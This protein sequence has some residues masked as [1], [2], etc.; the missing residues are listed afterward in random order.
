MPLT[1]R[2]ATL[3]GPEALT[4]DTCPVADPGPGE[5]RLRVTAALVGG[6]AAEIWRRGRHPRGGR[7]PSPFGHEGAGVIDAIG[8]G[9]T[10]WKP[11][12][13]VLAAGGVPCGTCEF[14][15]RGSAGQCDA[16][17]W[18]LGYA[19]ER[20]VVPAPIVQRS[21]HRLPDGLAPERAALAWELACVL[22]GFDRSPVGAGRTAVVIGAGAAGLLWVRTLS[23]AGARVVAVDRRRG[24]LEKAKS[25]GA[26]ETVDV[27]TSD[28]VGHLVRTKTEGGI[29]ADLVVECAGTIEAWERAA[30]IVRRGGTVHLYGAPRGRAR[31]Q[32]PP[33][34]VHGDEVTFLSSFHH[35]PE[36]VVQALHLLA[37][38][39]V[40]A[41]LFLEESAPVTRL[42]SVLGRIA[43]GEGPIKASIKV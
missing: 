32:V 10:G 43:S 18:L 29:G 24:R 4:L 17:V 6:T 22:K 21:L 12:D 23:K 9:V 5:V 15:R 2:A 36:H 34:R 38:G 19:G 30:G 11:G 1:Q 37:G 27:S 42:S 41:S 31:L 26:F 28:D 8:P 16:T 25:L 20:L 3:R 35:G 13:A 14:C 7:A 40:D 39:F 33:E